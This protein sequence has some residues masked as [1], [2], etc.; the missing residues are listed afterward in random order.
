MSA[1]DTASGTIAARPVRFLDT[2]TQTGIGLVVAPLIL[3][4][5]TSVFMLTAACGVPM[6][7]AWIPAVSTSGVMLVASRLAMR[8]GLDLHIKRYALWLAVAAV[9]IEMVVAG[10]QHALPETLN[11]PG[12]VKAMIG[13]LPTA[14]GGATFKIWSMASAAQDAANAAAQDAI[15][16]A[17]LA[18]ETARIETAAHAERIAAQKSAE[19][20]RQAAEIAHQRELTALATTAAAAEQNRAKAAATVAKALEAAPQRPHL[21]PDPAPEPTDALGRP[22]RVS[23]KRDAALRYLLTQRNRLNDVTAAEVDREIGA[24]GYARKHLTTWITD[25][26]THAGE[27]A[28]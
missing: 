23:P 7:A 6:W 28:A 20:Q 11:A 15:D 1:A 10:L 9:L 22:A 25:V 13:A 26:R 4:G 16:Q 21:V 18:A 12:L 27:G 19:S 8:Q 2:W 14:M 24:N 3:W 5:A 17:A